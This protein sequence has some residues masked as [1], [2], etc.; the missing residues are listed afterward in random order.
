MS[1]LVEGAWL[2]F[3]GDGRLDIMAIDGGSV[4]F[5]HNGK[6]RRLTPVQRMLD[7]RRLAIGISFVLC[8][9]VLVGMKRGR[10]MCIDMGYR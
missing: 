10:I 5:C 2:E 6:A 4:F 1:E 9:F 7:G 8:M 3:F